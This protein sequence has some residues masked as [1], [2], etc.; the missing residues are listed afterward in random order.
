MQYKVP[1]DVQREDK[2]IGPLTLKQMI[3]CGVGG[4]V[5]Y[6]IYVSLAKAYYMEI[7]LPPVV[8]IVAITS[9]FAFLKVH[10]L[11]FYVFLMNF[12]EYH[13]LPKKRVWIQGTGTPFTP[14]FEEKKEKKEE[15]KSKTKTKSPKIRN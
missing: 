12:I 13:L 14:P 15:K 4:G 1:Q 5:A 2:I 6:A 11:P 7:W 9:A 10:S 8:I 3:I